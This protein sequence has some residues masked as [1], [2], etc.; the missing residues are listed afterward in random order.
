MNGRRIAIGV[1]GG[2]AAATC[3]ASVAWACTFQPSIY[4]LSAQN[5]LPGS[6]VTVTGQAI[7]NHDRVEIRWNGATGPTLAVAPVE[8]NGSYS[9]PVTVPADAA[10]NVYMLVAVTDGVGVAR[11]AFEVTGVA[12]G[13]GAN[14]RGRAGDV[15]EFSQTGPNAPSP[16]A[17]GVGSQDSSLPVVVL[18]LSLVAGGMLLGGFALATA[19]RRRATARY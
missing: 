14:Q 6:T 13:S 16:N 8:G 9:V 5:G 11:S 10:P 3:A 18:G 4:H 15:W 7:P 2:A 12:P 17:T 19:G 1:F